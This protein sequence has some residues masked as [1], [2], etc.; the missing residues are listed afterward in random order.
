MERVVRAIRE[1]S[2]FLVTTHVRPD[3]DAAGSLLALT[4]MLKR[5]GKSAAPLTQDPLAPNC[6][7]LPGAEAIRHEVSEVSV[8]DAAILVD[9]GDFSRI[10]D[11]LAAVVRRIPFLINIDHHVSKAPFGNVAWVDSSASSTCEMLYDLCLSLPVEPDAAIATCLYTGLIT[12]TGSFQFSNTN[13]RVLEVA[14]ALVGAGAQP[15]AVASEI[16]DS[17]PPQRL[18]LL[19][20]VLSTVAFL[21]GNRLA[22]AAL[23]HQMLDETGAHPSDSEGFVNHLR[24]IRPVELAIFFRE[25]EDGFVHVSMRSKGKIDVAAFAQRFDG[26]GHRQAAAFHLP[27]N[28]EEIRSRYTAEALEYMKKSGVLP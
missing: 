2:H 12:D 7:F 6:E 3:G 5:L 20:R 24:S 8:F 26:G 22:T 15:A 4:A 10:G 28:L 1:R 14:S 18:L 17:A 11:G 13:R 21:A 9:C 16:Y 19:G 25:G 23:S 27:G